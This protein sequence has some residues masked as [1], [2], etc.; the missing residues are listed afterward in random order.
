AGKIKKAQIN[1]INFD[2][3]ADFR[4]LE[5]RHSGNGFSYAMQEG[6]LNKYGIL[7]LHQN[8]MSQSM[9]DT[10]H[11]N[12]NIQAHFFED[13]FVTQKISME[14][15]TEVLLYFTRNGYTGI[16]I[17]LDA[18]ENILSSAISPCG[19]S[20]TQARQF[21]H[22]T[23]TKNKIAYLHIC[24]G[25]VELDNGQKSSTIGKLISYLVSDFVKAVG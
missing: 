3:H 6:F 20:T 22:Q 4:A 15:A 10:I 9:L 13:I 7:G 21:I 25:A 1:V 16:E 5:G 12:K 11:K 23:A 14:Q 18:I 19:F 24:E 2:A 17:D 8:Y